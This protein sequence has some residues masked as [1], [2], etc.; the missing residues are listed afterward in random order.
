MTAIAKEISLRSEGA[1]RSIAAATIA[2]GAFL[3]FL[4]EPMAAKQLLPAMG[5]SSSVWLACLTFFQVALLLGYT[6]AFL[7]TRWIER[8]KVRPGWLHVS[9]LV[10]AAIWAIS[11]LFSST[12]VSVS[13]LGHPVI[14]IFRELGKRIGL[15]FLLLSSTSP[16]LQVWMSQRDRRQVRYRLFAVSNLG[17]LVA[18]LAYPL[19][20]EPHFSLRKQYV[21]WTSGFVLYAILCGWLALRSGQGTSSDGIFSAASVS[22]EARHPEGHGRLWMCFL[23]GAT[24]SV[25]LTAVTSHLTENI[26]AI[27]LL[28]VIPLAVY[29]LSFIAAFEAPRMYRR[30]PVLRL[31][32]VMLAS[33]GYLLSKTDV[34]LPIGLGMIFF[35]A[36]LFLASWFCNAEAYRLRPD[37]SADAALFYLV[38][39]AGSAAG[40]AIAV[41]VAPM[42]FDANYDL[43]L[44]FA[45]TACTAAAVTWQG[46]WTRRLL[47][48]T[49]T[50]LCL[51]LAARLH[52]AYARGALFMARNFYGSLRVK[53]QELPPQAGGSRMLLHGSIEHGMQWF[54]P[55]FRSLPL[56]YYAPDSGVGVAL[57]ECCADKPRKIGVIGLGAGTLAAYGRPGDAIRFYE[58]NPLIEQIARGL[59]SYGR[60]SKATI[61]VVDGDARRSLTEEQDA[62]FDVLVIDAFS[63]DAIPVH[64]LTMEALEL[65][66]RRLLPD[67]V[68]AFHVSNQYVNL[69]PLLLALAHGKHLEAREVLSGSRPET[70][71]F[72][73]TWVLVGEA[74]A[75][76][77]RPHVEPSTTGQEVLQPISALPGLQPWTDDRSTLLPLLRWGGGSR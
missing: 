30:E 42:L 63:G 68:I 76:I 48:C 14:T 29:L 27:P 61:T 72:A 41:I 47:W 45:L 5:G 62:R 60:E 64:L 39:A 10:I 43:P 21:L 66:R 75:P 17:S 25:Q 4:L 53:Q 1:Q 74:T 11:T 3:L 2:L 52:T 70:G 24:G 13:A 69:P 9:L 37:R 59:F 36:E 67:G 51:L 49:S 33:L 71:E 50:A 65:Y 15:P 73:A 57:R 22:L 7:L 16:L 38:L 44:D 23:L 40:T 35:L 34:S 12:L 58:I 77:F 6:Y 19:V 56:T 26:A 28:W 20:I 32:V 18:L 31:L 46:G 8:F 54:A 55:E